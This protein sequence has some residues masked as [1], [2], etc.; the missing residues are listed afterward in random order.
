LIIRKNVENFSKMI[1]IDIHPV[2]MWSRKMNPFL[3]RSLMTKAFL[4]SV[5]ISGTANAATAKI[6]DFIVI[7]TEAAMKTGEYYDRLIKMSDADLKNTVLAPS[8]GDFITVKKGTKSLR[9]GNTRVFLLKQRGFGSLVVTYDE[10]ETGFR[11][12]DD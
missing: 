12:Y 9:D 7:H 8:G 4:F 5:L 1:H 6:S 3:K 10:V 2:C 11:F